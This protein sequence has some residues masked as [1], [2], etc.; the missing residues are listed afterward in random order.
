MIRIMNEF[1]PIAVFQAVAGHGNFTK[2]GEHLGLTQPAVSRC[3]T[4][5]EHQLGQAA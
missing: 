2:A 4:E 1:A 3:V 5:L